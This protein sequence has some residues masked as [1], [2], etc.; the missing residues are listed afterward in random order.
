MDFV[1]NQMFKKTEYDIFQQIA[2]I[3]NYKYG[4]NKRFS[5]YNQMFTIENTGIISE[6]QKPL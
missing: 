4:I 5:H 3:Q 2:Q 6:C 1:N